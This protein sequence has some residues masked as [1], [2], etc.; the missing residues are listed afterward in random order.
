MEEINANKVKIYLKK[1]FIEKNY[2]G[3]LLLLPR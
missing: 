2:V 3:H 1:I